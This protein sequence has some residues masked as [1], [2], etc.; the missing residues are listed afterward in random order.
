MIGYNHYQTYDAQSDRR[1]QTQNY[2][3]N[4]KQDAE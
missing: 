2:P 4:N 1:F 3:K